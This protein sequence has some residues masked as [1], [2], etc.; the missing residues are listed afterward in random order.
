MGTNVIRGPFFICPALFS[1]ILSVSFPDRPVSQARI[2][3]PVR[4]WS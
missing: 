4:A 2:F 1:C 3:I